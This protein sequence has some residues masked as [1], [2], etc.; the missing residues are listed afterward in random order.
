M[1]SAHISSGMHSLVFK[2]PHPY[3]LPHTEEAQGQLL[4][5]IKL[6][7]LSFLCLFI[8]ATFLTH[9]D[10]EVV[11]FAVRTPKGIWNIY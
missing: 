11:T 2:I 1:E 5:I 6:S 7:S 3:C 4:F 8:Y 10:F 9:I